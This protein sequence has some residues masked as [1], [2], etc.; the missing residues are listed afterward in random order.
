[1]ATAVAVK[2][3]WPS[4]RAERGKS[5]KREEEGFAELLLKVPRAG[6]DR[7]WRPQ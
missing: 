4:G 2:G 7:R 6:I 1:M 3:G 5:E